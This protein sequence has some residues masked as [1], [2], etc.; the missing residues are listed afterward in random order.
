MRQPTSLASCYSHG[1]MF[2]EGPEKKVEIGLRPGGRDIRGLGEAF[3][4][5]RVEEAGAVVLSA[6]RTPAVDAYL[7]SESSL[8]VYPR[9]VVM[10]TCGRT[11]LA[12]A[13]EAMLDTWNGEVQ[14]LIYERKNEHFPEYQ[15][16][17][18][19]ED[20]RSLAEKLPS[21]SWRFGAADGHRIQILSSLAPFSPDREERTLEIL[22][23]GI[24]PEAAAMFGRA[25]QSARGPRLD[26]FRALFEGFAVD[27]HDFQPTGYSMNALRGREYITVHVTPEEIAS[28]VSFETNI[29]FGE[30]PSPWVERVRAVF[31]PRS[32]DVLTFSSGPL[33]SFE[34][35]GHHVVGWAED[36]LPCGFFVTFRHHERVRA[37]PD[38]A[39]PLP[40]ASTH[41]RA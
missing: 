28:Y 41:P 23:H 30:D 3:W 40:L 24:H 13:T 10:I 39:F 4:G 21:G 14:Y 19:L 18:F 32:F 12:T 1:S 22:M 29:S 7:L 36:T 11:N 9:R 38:P 17:G 6:M 33:Q 27:E 2:F 37:R 35:P 34:I 31:E 15:P 20:A 16:T 26:A 25:R 5:A 8:F